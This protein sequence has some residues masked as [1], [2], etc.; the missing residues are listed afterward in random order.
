VSAPASMNFAVK[1]PRLVEEDQLAAAVWY[2]E[3]QPGLGDEFLDESEA[4]ITSL[5]E[6]VLLYAVRFEDVR[7]VRLKR[8]HKYGVYYVIRGNEIRLLAIHHGSR[9][10]RWLRE[11]TNQL[12]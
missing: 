10:D 4:V 7:C 1:R 12:R 3:Q 6:N 9:D 2:D 8:F 5:V 11:R